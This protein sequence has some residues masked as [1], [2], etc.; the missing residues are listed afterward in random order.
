VPILLE[1]TR[2]SNHIGYGAFAAPQYARVESRGT[3]K[4]TS[5][6][7][8]IAYGSPLLLLFA[9]HLFLNS[10]SR[11]LA[12]ALIFRR[13]RFLFAAGALARRAGAAAVVP[14]R[15]AMALVSLSRSVFSAFRM[16]SSINCV[17][18]LFGRPPQD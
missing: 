16:V 10:E 3:L 18:Y 13:P 5:I 6:Y 4:V 8:A 9:H 15:A 7:T 1:H 11:C 14:S 17:S 12:S 2:L